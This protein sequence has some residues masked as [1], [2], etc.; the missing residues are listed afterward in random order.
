MVGGSAAP[1][2]KMKQLTQLASDLTIQQL[3]LAFQHLVPMFDSSSSCKSR[4]GTAGLLV[5]D[6]DMCS[7]S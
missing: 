1:T 5:A 4:L 3:L 2:G 6:S 7:C